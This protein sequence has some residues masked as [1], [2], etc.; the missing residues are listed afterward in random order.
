MCNFISKIKGLALAE[1]IREYG[2][3]GDIGVK[4]VEVARELRS[5]HNHELH[6][7]YSSANIR[8]IKSRIRWMGH[9]TRV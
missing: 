6:Y 1:G 7:F 8:V 3:E 5:I 4:R 2:A 9:G